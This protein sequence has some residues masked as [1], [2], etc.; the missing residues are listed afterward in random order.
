MVPADGYLVIG[1]KFL[2]EIDVGHQPGAGKQPLE[3]IV[4]E[5]GVVR[6]P[7]RQIRVH[8]AGARHDALVGRATRPRGEGWGDSRLENRVASDHPLRPGVEVGSIQRVRHRPD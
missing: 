4:A 2:E 5:E 8:P 7:L 6:N 1:G 3:E